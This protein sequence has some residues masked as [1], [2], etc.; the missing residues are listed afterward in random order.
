MTLSTISIIRTDEGFLPSRNA[1]IRFDSTQ[2]KVHVMFR[3]SMTVAERVATALVVE[4]FLRGV[5]S[6][7]D[8]HADFRAV[9]AP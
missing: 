6:P 1:V 4:C 2:S 9:I 8:Y 3:H 7:I 5:Y